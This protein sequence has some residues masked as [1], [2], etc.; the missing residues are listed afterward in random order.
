MLGFLLPRVASLSDGACYLQAGTLIPDS[1]KP[2]WQRVSCCLSC[3]VRISVSLPAPPLVG[4]RNI[5]MFTKDA[6][7]AAGAGSSFREAEFCPPKLMP[8]LT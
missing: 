4:K 2:Q 1:V 7:A 6:F 3:L 8:P 5:G